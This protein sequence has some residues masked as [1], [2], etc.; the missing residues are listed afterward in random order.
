MTIVQPNHKSPHQSF[1]MSRDALVVGINTYQNLN[2]LKAPAADAE[3]I[4]VS[5]EALPG[6]CK[7]GQLKC[8]KVFQLS[9]DQRCN[10]FS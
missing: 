7:N 3:A 8:M 5:W 2:L 6:R 4:A 9:S 10:I 1:C